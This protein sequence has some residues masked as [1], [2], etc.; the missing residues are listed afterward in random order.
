MA[1]GKTKK[2]AK[3]SAGQN[4]NLT[5]QYIQKYQQKD[6]V[7][8]LPSGLMFRVVQAAEGE[9]PSLMHTVKVQQRIL[10]AD[11]SVIDDTYKKGLPEEFALEEAIE[12]LQEAIPMMPVGSRYEFVIPPELAWGKKGNG[13]KIGPNAVMIVDVRLVSFE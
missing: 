4:K 5:E 7:E 3:G 8:T 10:L 13:G 9:K 1:K 6:G 12:G 11:G 2:T